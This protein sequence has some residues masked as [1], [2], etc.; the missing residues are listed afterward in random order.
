MEQHWDFFDDPEQKKKN[1][2]SISPM[3]QHWDFFDDPE[4]KKKESQI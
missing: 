1:L 4:Q 2:R 3:E